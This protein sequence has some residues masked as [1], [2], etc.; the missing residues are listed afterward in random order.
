MSY[1]GISD[2]DV[3]NQEL[4]KFESHYVELLLGKYDESELMKRAPM[5]NLLG[6]TEPLLLIQGSDEPDKENKQSKHIFTVLKN[7]GVPIAYL[8]FDGEQYRLRDPKNKATAMEAELSFYGTIFGFTPADDIPKLQ[9][10]NAKHL[11]SIN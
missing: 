6:F 1:S 9:L 7:K 2:I 4:H 3:L 8:S 5:H 11:K 10:I